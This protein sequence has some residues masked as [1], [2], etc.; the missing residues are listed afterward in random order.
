MEGEGSGFQPGLQLKGA[1]G[2]TS[3][4]QMKKEKRD[5]VHGW[6][7]NFRAQSPA[8]ADV[9]HNKRRRG[10]WIHSSSPG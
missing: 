4:L 10:W 1:T 6:S 3:L 8:E 7:D 5:S 2:S 9:K